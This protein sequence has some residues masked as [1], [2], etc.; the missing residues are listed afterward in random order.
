VRNSLFHYSEKPFRLKARRYEQES[1]WQLSA[2]CKPNGLWVSVKGGQDWEAFCRGDNFALEGLKNKTPI[3]VKPEA[4]ILWVS[5]VKEFDTFAEKYG[6][7]AKYGDHCIN[8]PKV[9]TDF[10]GI[11]IA[12]YIWQRRLHQGSSWYYGWDCASGCIWN[13]EAIEA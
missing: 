4:N 1:N 10:D 7:P 2:H 12:P 13:L 9:A 11:I 8:W 3:A 6:E 5:G